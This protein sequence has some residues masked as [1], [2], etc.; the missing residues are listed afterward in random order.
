LCVLQLEILAKSTGKAESVIETDI[1]R[2]LYFDPVA[3]KEYG[4]I[5]TVRGEFH[6]H[7]SVL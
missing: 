4:L 3:A 2:P 7:R 6:V 5:D 1:N